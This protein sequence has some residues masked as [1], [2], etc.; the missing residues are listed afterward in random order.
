MKEIAQPLI[1]ALLAGVGVGQ[2]VGQR[3]IVPAIVFGVV[4]NP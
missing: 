3:P 4:G 1:G 2:E